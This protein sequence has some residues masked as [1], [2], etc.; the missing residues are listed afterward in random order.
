MTRLG[1]KITHSLLKGAK[2]SNVSGIDSRINVL[3]KKMKTLIGKK[4]GFPSAI[5]YEVSPD[6]KTVSSQLLKADKNSFRQFDPW[7]LAFVYFAQ[8]TLKSPIAGVTF[9][10]SSKLP[11]S[12]N[13]PQ[14]FEAFKRRVS[15]LKLNNASLDMD[16]EITLDGK[17]VKLYD[18]K[19]L[20]NRPSNEVIHTDIVD[21]DD[22]DKPGRLEKVFQAFLYGKDLPVRTNDRLAILG[23]HFLDIKGKNIDILR[24]FPTGVFDK[25]I[26]KDSRIMMTDY[27]DL[28]SLNKY[29]RLS[30]IELKVDDNAPLELISQ[31]LDYALFFSCYTDQLLK[32]GT[33]KEK[34]KDSIR[35]EGIDCYAVANHF[36]PNLEKIWVYY[37]TGDNCNFKL[38]RV[39]LGKTVD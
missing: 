6:G 2:M 30:V 35:K 31:T 13:F 11:D 29:G 20:F 10:L 27:V 22:K 7:T 16:F 4:G 9:Q 18:I 32:T 14:F 25:K 26:G 3:N 17:E 24:E 8:E 34:L 38:Y 5:K 39:H 19:S 36:H 28:V 12:K 1:S 21:R 37:H 15:F 23:E 33:I